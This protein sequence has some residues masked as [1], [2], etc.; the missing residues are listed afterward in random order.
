[1]VREQ[2]SH[3]PARVRRVVVFALHD[4][5]VDLVDEHDGVFVGTG[6]LVQSFHHGCAA[7][8]R[9]GLRR[10]TLGDRGDSLQRCIFPM[11]VDLIRRIV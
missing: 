4:Q 1:M 10:G 11:L 2:F 5:A 8:L 9:S 6:A 7:S 3:D